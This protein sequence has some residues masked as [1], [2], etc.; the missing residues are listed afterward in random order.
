MLKIVCI[1]DVHGKWNK[2]VIPE[3]DILISTGDY[4]FTGEQHMVRDFHKWLNK[5]KATHII[6]VQGN[7]EKWPEKNFQLAKE[8][9]TTACPRVHFMEE[10][11]VEVEGIKIWCSAI[12]PYFHNWAYNR[13]R[14]EDI[15]KHWDR[16][17]DDLLNKPDIIA[18]HGPAY[19]ILDGVEK[20]NSL[21]QKNE[22]EH[23]GCEEL[24]KR[25]QEIKPKAHFFGHTHLQYGKIEVGGTTFFNCANCDDEYKLVRPPTIFEI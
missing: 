4:S 18:T 19:G 15:K 1:S 23:V 10:G 13:F 16:I 6:S 12:T 9:A 3:C 25:I 7:H 24:L 8:I 5:Q 14:G 2:L 22:L 11:L 17:P 21:T 20:Y